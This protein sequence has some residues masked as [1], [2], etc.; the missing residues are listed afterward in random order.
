MS[1]L[2]GLCPSCGAFVRR[3]W[4]ETCGRCHAVLVVPEASA[5]VRPD[6]ENTPGGEGHFALPPTDLSPASPSESRPRR[7][8][9]TIVAGVLGVLVLLAGLSGAAYYLAMDAEKARPERTE[10][11]VLMEAIG[12]APEETSTTQVGNSP[13]APTSSPVERRDSDLARLIGGSG[14]PSAKPVEGWVTY[15]DPNGLFTA[16]MPTAPT[17]EKID[18]FGGGAIKYQF[19]FQETGFVATGTALLPSTYNDRT[20]RG[21]VLGAMASEFKRIPEVTPGSVRQST[22]QGYGCIEATLGTEKVRVLSARVVLMPHDVVYLFAGDMVKAN[23]DAEF[24]QFVNNVSLK[25]RV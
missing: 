6:D 8:T 14:S 23:V 18:L 12:I 24:D 2:P 25:S 3:D 7:L 10:P 9:K 13:S 16:K 4:T 20:E 19:S 21:E 11:R 15:R 1:T 5:I 17:P 22:M